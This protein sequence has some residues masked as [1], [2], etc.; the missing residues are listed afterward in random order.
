MS[1]VHYAIYKFP[2]VIPNISP[3][4]P[5]LPHPAEI[6]YYPGFTFSRADTTPGS[7]SDGLPSVG[8][9]A[10]DVD[11]YTG[12]RDVSSKIGVPE[13]FWYLIEGS[14][15]NNVTESNNLTAWG[16]TGTVTVTPGEAGPNGNDAFRVESLSGTHYISRAVG[17]AVGQPRVVTHWLRQGPGS[18]AYQTLTTFA[19]TG[20]QARGGTASTSWSRLRLFTAATTGVGAVHLQ[21]GRNLLASPPAGV[22]A[23]ARDAVVAYVQGE[24]GYWASSY[25]ATAGSARTR[26]ADILRLALPSWWTTETLKFELVPAWSSA[27]LMA[28]ALPAAVLL[29]NVGGGQHIFFGDRSLVGGPAGFGCVLSTATVG[30]HWTDVFSVAAG[31]LLEVEVDWNA[32]EFSV[33][34]NSV[35]VET[36]PFAG[37]WTPGEWGIGR[38]TV[39]AGGEVYGLLRILDIP[40]EWMPQDPQT[41]EGYTFTRASTATDGLPSVGLPAGDV[42]SYGSNVL[43]KVSQAGKYGAASDGWMLIEGART[44]VVT[45]ATTMAG[46]DAGTVTVTSGQADPLGGTNAHRFETAGGNNYRTLPTPGSGSAGN[47]VRASVFVRDANT[48]QILG[49]G[50]STATNRRAVGGTATIWERAVVGNITPLDALVSLVMTVSDARNLTSFGGLAQAARDAV[51]AFPQVEANVR[52][53]SSYIPTSG[54][55]ATRLGDDLSIDLPERWTG[56]QLRVEFVPAYSSAERVG[57]TQDICLLREDDEA[58]LEVVVS[59]SDMI[60]RLRTWDGVHDGNPLVWAAGDEV[61]F[62]VDWVGGFFSI[63]INDVYTDD[64]T[65]TGG[66]Q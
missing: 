65:F 48:F 26:G 16:V 62:E 23:G 45:N 36:V 33:Y 39:A 43:R 66:W 29:E 3:P 50:L 13:D 25:I 42:D 19:G 8:L 22:A 63:F 1:F 40:P 9:P 28:A 20:E 47:F 21:D 46:S 10:D 41:L 27:E 12:L 18:G 60:P 35:L 38:S 6:V 44:N 52:W 2:R 11:F 55:A 34:Q 17:T 54:S 57:A 24:Q 5:V 58:A 53:A 59:G 31:D 7:V 15:T 51:Y 30:S 49:G 14:R 61:R 4:I 37:T 64:F 32:G 56:G